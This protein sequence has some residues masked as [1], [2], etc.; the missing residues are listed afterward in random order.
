M[1]TVTK[2][3][4][5]PDLRV[6]PACR[7][8]HLQ[9]GQREQVF[10]PHRLTLVVPLLTSVCDHCGVEVASAAQHDENL[11]RLAAR[12]D[13][14][15]GLLLGEE[16]S[17]LR[18]RYGLTQ[19]L[20]ARV[21]GKSKIAFSRYESETTYPDASTTLLISLAIA[22]PETLK[23]LADRAGIS[24]PLWQERCQDARPEATTALQSSIA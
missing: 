11:R 23:W 19:E 7:K 24:I 18:R 4:V 10:R 3:S 22:Q 16:I 13:N 1:L 5:A 15:A 14:Y 8:G 2:P 12:K 17:A 20:A 21:F 9:E 6:C